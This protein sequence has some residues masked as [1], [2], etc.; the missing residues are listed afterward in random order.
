MHQLH[1]TSK[2]LLN[3]NEVKTNDHEHIHTWRITMTTM[4]VAQF[5]VS[6]AK[7]TQHKLQLSAVTEEVS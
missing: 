3:I 2:I 5:M 4:V 6:K 1:A 7:L